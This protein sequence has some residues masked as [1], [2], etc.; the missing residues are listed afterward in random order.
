MTVSLYRKYRPQTFD[1]I[2]GQEHVQKTLMNAVG[3][4]KMSHAYLFCGP[5]GTGKTTTAR[6]LAKALLCES[7]GSGPTAKPDGT[8]EQCR[9]IANGTHPDVYELDAASRTG[10][11]NIREEIIS[12]V[13]FAPSRGAY[14][15]YI[16]DEVHMLSTPAFNALLLT[17]EEPPPHIVFILCTTDVHKVPATILSRC[18]RFDFRRLSE[19]QIVGRLSEI[20]AKEGF[21]AQP[22]ALELIAARSQGGMRD[23]ISAL[24]QVA[25]FGSGQ[26]RF[27]AVEDLLGE[28]STLQLFSLADYVAD[29]NATGCFSW[30]ASF[31]QG[32][33]D[34]ALFANE[35]AGHMRNLY[36]VLVVKDD[37]E[38]TNVFNGDAELLERYRKQAHRFGSVDRLAH[39]LGVLSDLSLELKSAP[40]AR[41][42]LEIALTR[43][44][45]PASDLTLEALAARVVALE[46]DIKRIVGQGPVEQR[47]LGI[48]RVSGVEQSAEEQASGVER[49]AEEQA[50]GVERSAK[51]V[52][53]V[54]QSVGQVS[55]SERE[56]TP[57]AISVSDAG[58]HRL[59]L[60]VE[61][62]VKKKGSIFSSLLSGTEA[63][64]DAN[65]ETLTVVLPENASFAKKTL[66]NPAN[67]ELVEKQINEVFGRPYRLTYVLG[68]IGKK[69]NTKSI[70]E[71]N[72]AAEEQ[73][74]TVAA[75]KKDYMPTEQSP[76]SMGQSPASKEQFFALEQQTHTVAQENH[77]SA[78]TNNAATEQTLASTQE[79]IAFE[80]MLS[81]SFGAAITF[82][83]I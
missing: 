5:R 55:D 54:E 53:G 3:T 82:E 31:A 60:Q 79:K 1:D 56:K 22:G 36:A 57:P 44:V 32:A 64:F 80:E 43:I 61:G 70:C 29:R 72:Y 37:A 17:L 40:N 18:Q 28:V 49:G 83:E 52:S 45:R 25:V 12:R 42:A 50:S 71:Q 38:L 26:V 24:E 20:C 7:G 13:K 48:E 74:Y 59:W 81:K 8:C 51:R 2:V 16:I 14:K 62:E 68:S 15:V 23:A 78:E 58:V 73:D 63:Y 67:L 66:E 69:G 34:I 77:A 4:D 41:L 6:L 76:A 75:V 39:V 27:E 9:E 33:T 46:Q 65:K 21:I 47:F 30:V 19:A 10:V 11:E 35:F